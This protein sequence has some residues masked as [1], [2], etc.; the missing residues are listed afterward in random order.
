MANFLRRGTTKAYFL[1]TIASAT[2]APT[3]AEITAGTWLS[4]PSSTNTLAEVSGFNSKSTFIDIPN[5]GSRQTP[6]IPGEQQSDDSSMQFYEDTT[7]NPIRTL[8]PRDTTGFIVMAKNG[9]TT[10]SGKVDVFPVTV[11]ANTALYTTGNEAAKFQVDFA[12][13]GIPVQDIAPL[14]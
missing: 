1:P 3:Q 7:T 11:G 2:L 9:V 4:N 10:T 14:T 8:L 13:T 6:K 5:F 12:I